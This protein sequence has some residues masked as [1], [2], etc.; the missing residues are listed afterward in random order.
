MPRLTVNGIDVTVPEGTSLLDAARV[1]G[2]DVPTVCH[3]PRLAPAGSCRLCIVS[4]DGEPRPVTSCSTPARDGAV[5]TTSRAQLE[6]L[7]ATVRQMLEE[8]PFTAE[9]TVDETHPLIRV[10][11]GRCVSCWRCVRICDE[12]QGQ[13]VW[14]LAGR[15]A[16]TRV[17]TDGDAGFG[18]SSCVSCGACVDTC[19]TGALEDRSVLHMGDAESWT[20]TTCPYCGVGCELLVGVRGG[21]IV[22][23]RPALDAPVN[24]GH[25]CVKGRYGFGFVNAADRLR[26]PLI[27]EGGVLREAT[28]DEA[29]ERVASGFRA[30]LDHHGPASVGVLGSA[31]ATNE[32]NYLTQKFARVVLGTNNVDSCARVCHAPSA[33]ALGAVFGT[34]AATSSFDDIERAATILVCGANATENHPI[35]GARIKQAALRGA[36][37]VVVDPRR[38]EL[39]AFADI[40]LRP[41]PGSNVALFNAIAN[42]IISEGL[43]DEEFVASRVDGFGELRSAVAEWTPERAASVCGVD[44]EQIRAVGRLVAT[45]RPVI[46][47]HGL[48]MTEHEQGTDGVVAI[49]NLALL[50]GNVGR[51]GAGVNPLRGQNNVQ[52]AAHMGCEPSKLTGYQPIDTAKERF[53]GVWG[54]PVP[55][56]PGLDAMQLLDA[57]HAGRLR[58]LWVIGWDIALTQPNAKATAAALEQ[59]DL[60]VVSDLFLDETARRYA[61]VVLPAASA[62]EKDGTFMNGERRVQRVRAAVSPV[63]GARTDASIIS[64]VAAAMGHADSFTYHDPADV[65]DEVRKVWPAG[66]GITYERLDDPGGLQWPCPDV[67]HPGTALLHTT[68]FTGAPR[69]AM[70]ALQVHPLHEETTPELPF[71]LVTGRDLYK[72]NAGTMTGRSATALLRATDVLE[73]SRVDAEPLGI[74]DGDAVVVTSRYGHATLAAELTDRVPPGVVFATFTDPVINVNDVTNSHRDAI[75]HTPAYK[76]TAVAVRRA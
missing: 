1:A 33:A 32:E 72:F 53:A 35:V 76:M 49:A 75:T 62:F 24:N 66:A 37:L 7:R 57:A 44:A 73:L 20:R 25:A 68:A 48:G 31:R 18:T 74:S 39:A 21:R 51:P 67:D 70:R 17:V 11:L 12:V 15:G 47:F 64:A 4:V 34:G 45:A 30:T 27:R 54:A 14:R 63:G 6:G 16:D 2:V 22:Q 59:L 71:A 3:D 56:Q 50:T 19:P 41:R 10:D 52:G 38:I 58:A 55:E 69:A 26:T 46:S 43:V 8:R 5:V 61:T 65:W 29:V 60:L 42:A 13:F 28:W 40:H 23:I 9:D 36:N